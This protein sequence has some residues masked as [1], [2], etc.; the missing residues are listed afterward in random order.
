MVL[1]VQRMAKPTYNP[2]TRTVR[3][4]HPC[5][6]WFALS[7]LVYGSREPPI[8][9]AASRSKET[10]DENHLSN[11]VVGP[12]AKSGRA[13][14]SLRGRGRQSGHGRARL[15]P[16]RTVRDAWSAAATGAPRGA[17]RGVAQPDLCAQPLA[18]RRLAI[19]VT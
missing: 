2:F 9:R 8:P 4:D 7:L 3:P 16:A 1:G 18:V 5:V 13:S 14:R 6:R 11:R 17:K 15:L 10:V 12:G 19:R